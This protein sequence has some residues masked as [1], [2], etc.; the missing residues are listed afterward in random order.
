MDRFLLNTN[1]LCE[2]EN[3]E[4]TSSTSGKSGTKREIENMM[5]AIWTLVLRRQKSM[6]K[7]GRN[8]FCVRKFWLQSACY[9]VSWNAI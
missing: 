4:G 5:T 7:R 1:K 9:Q 6:A 2:S 3:K 8:V